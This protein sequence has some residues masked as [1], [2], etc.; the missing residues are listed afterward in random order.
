MNTFPSI[1]II[2]TVK[3][4]SGLKIK[5]KYTIIIVQLKNQQYLTLVYPRKNNFSIHEHVIMNSTI[6]EMR[7]KIYLHELSFFIDFS[8]IKDA[9]K[10]KI[11]ASFILS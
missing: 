10:A 9:T 8:S 11:E 7:S 1:H 5:K 2:S 3:F 4:S 6:M